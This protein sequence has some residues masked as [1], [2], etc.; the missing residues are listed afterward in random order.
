VS[1]KNG[2]YCIL[3]KQYTKEEYEALVPKIIEHM[4]KTGEWGEFFPMSI[5]PLAY[6]QTIAQDYFPFTEEKA[7]AAGARWN[8][9][10]ALEPPANVPVLPDDIR[11]TDD[12]ICDQI[13]RCETSGKPYKIIPAE[14]KFYRRLGLPPPS[15]SFMERH[16]ARLRS[17]N[18][19][20]LWQRACDRC[21]KSIETS[22]APERPETVY[23]E[24]CYRASIS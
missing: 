12:S 1:I 18:P 11:D 22:Y 13:L 15:A 7:R 24:E 5:C 17:R 8:R 6:N 19:H 9:E 2:Q 4:R 21:M 20:Q 3:N 10:A 14:L 23:C 16:L